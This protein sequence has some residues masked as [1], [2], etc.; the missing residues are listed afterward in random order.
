MYKNL[1]PLVLF[2]L[3]IIFVAHME[4]T[5]QIFADN[6]FYFINK[7]GEVYSNRFNRIKKMKLSKTSRGYL[8]V[9][10][11]FNGFPKTY[12]VHRLVAE[13]FLQREKGREFV[14][15]IDGNKLNNNVENLEWCTH[16]ENN[17]HRFI[18]KDDN[19]KS[20]VSKRGNKWIATIYHNSKL[21]Y[22]G[23]YDT[24]D[25]AYSVRKNYEKN[26]LIENKY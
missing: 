1:R 5:K 24:Q 11:S 10:F 16:L 2:N 17:C 12:A 19:K 26:N 14:N 25:E 20:G 18:I 4:N 21:N 23:T 9:R 22:L 15:H 6:S 3:I 7:E 13:T 8:S